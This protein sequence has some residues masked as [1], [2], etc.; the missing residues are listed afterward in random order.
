[1]EEFLGFKRVFPRGVLDLNIL[2]KLSLDVALNRVFT[3]VVFG[4]AKTS[5]KDAIAC[6]HSASDLSRCLPHHLCEVGC[7]GVAGIILGNFVGPV[8]DTVGNAIAA[9]PSGQVFTKRSK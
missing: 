2:G 5:G 1:V 4:R 6:L 8:F 9:S 7:D 3:D